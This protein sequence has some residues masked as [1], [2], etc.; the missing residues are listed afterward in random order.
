MIDSAI[1][2]GILYYEALTSSALVW[3]LAFAL[4]GSCLLIIECILFAHGFKR[5]A[6]CLFALCCLYIPVSNLELPPYS[7]Y[8]VFTYL[9]SLA[10]DITILLFISSTLFYLLVLR[11]IRRVKQQRR[12]VTPITNSSRRSSELQSRSDRGRSS[13]VPD[14]CRNRTNKK[15][16][17]EPLRR[18]RITSS[19]ILASRLYTEDLGRRAAYSP[20]TLRAARTARIERERNALRADANA[21]LERAQNHLEQCL[22]ELRI[23][24]EEAERASARREAAES[25]DADLEE[26]TQA[27]QKLEEQRSRAS[28]AVNSAHAVLRDV[29]IWVA[30]L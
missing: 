8:F 9:G 20:Q 14:F 28:N 5:V 11:P 25:G 13:S 16:D 15:S 4:S 21:Q 3:R 1:A 18:S 6:L 29:E 23:A 17:P 19:H 30:S 22:V 7:S 26:L 27:V 24:D 2:A 10:F 12:T